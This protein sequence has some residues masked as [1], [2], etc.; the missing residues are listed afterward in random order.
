MILRKLIATI[1]IIS[2]WVSYGQQPKNIEQATLVTR[3]T[4]MQVVESFHGKT[5]I[6]EQPKSGD[7]N[8][9]T[10]DAN[11]VVPG[12]GFPKGQDP[13]LFRQKNYK[14]MRITSPPSLTFEAGSDL[15]S[16]TDPTGAVGPNHYVTAK[17]FSFTI[18]DK[19][20]NVL[21]PQTS[22]TNIFPNE[23]LG[24]PIVLYDYFADRFVITQF[25]K[26]P[27]SFLIAVSQ[28]NDPVNDGWY[29]YRFETGSFPDYPKFSVWSDG[30]YVTSNKSQNSQQTSEVVF[31]I[32]RE[33][34]LAGIPS[35]QMIGFPLPGA[36][37]GG[38]YS[39]AGFNVIGGSP[40]P[41]G[42]AKIVYFQDDA[43][44]DVSEDAIKL[45]TINVDW[46]NP[47][48]STIEEAE[49]FTTGN[50]QIT[51]FDSSFDGSSFSNLPQP[52]ENSQ[53]IDV[54]QGVVMFA[55]NYRRFCDYNS[56]LLNF[57]VD[58]DDREN[59][60]NIAAIRWYE[61]RQN[62]DDQSWEV[63]QEGTY[64]SPEGKSAWCAS[65]AMDIYGNIGMAYTTIGTI[66]NGATENSFPSI[67]Y[68]GRM[69]GD[70]LGIM[71]FSEQT[72]IAGTDIQRNGGERYGDYA[73]MTVDPIDDQTFW[74]IAEYF[75]NT[76]DNARNIVG[77]FSL[78]E[79]VIVDV[80]I[81]KIQKPQ[82]LT[83]TGN[84]VISIDI[85]NYGTSTLTEIPVQYSINNGEP[86][87]E[88][89]SGSI[90]P[91]AS[92]S[93]SFSTTADLSMDASYTIEART[94]LISDAIA[95][96]NCSNT[97]LENIFSNDV[98]V[99]DLVEPV[100][101]SA[102]KQI[103]TITITIQNLGISPQSNIPVYYI[104][105]QGQ[106]VN[107]TFTGTIDPG[108]TA[109]YTFM[110]TQDFFELGLYTLEVGTGLETDQNKN[111]D[112]I[113]RVILN[114]ICSPTSNCSLTKDGLTSFSLANITN[115]DITCNNGY[116]NFSDLI[117]NLDRSVGIYQLTVRAGFAFEDFERMTLWIDLDNNNNFESS[118]IFIDQAVLN[119]KDKD[120][121]FYISLPE[122]IA[123][124]IHKMRVKAGDINNNQNG[125]PFNESCGSIDF[126]TVHDYTLFIE[127]NN[128]ENEDIQ[129]I[130]RPN[131]LFTITM[132]DNSAPD[133]LRI[134]ILDIH[135]RVIVSN[136]VNKD[137][138]GRFIFDNL[139]MSYA[140]SGLYFVQLGGKKHGSSTKFIVP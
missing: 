93:Y 88:I 84:E 128:M 70:P 12:K 106:I 118:E 13:L 18:F 4:S 74:H 62:G 124:G 116:E 51:P 33:K 85:K 140:S 86:I 108:Q 120:L 11:R 38:F 8:P 29:T 79:P 78:A 105:N 130:S 111:N 91:G 48:Q 109:E 65:M 68:T 20:G 2:A 60:D 134:Y 28:G 117:I 137:T 94:E 39:P 10:K 23:S 98:R 69:D 99:L 7:I 112:I 56:V 35:A 26:T 55:T 89:Y 83:L 135:G 53:E 73:H 107:E 22:L 129:V 63:F 34:V 67:R 32:E 133:R 96:N 3:A 9:K 21:Q 126:G 121:D 113:T 100:S 66:E 95:K 132:T 30:Y 80:G 136:M 122:D 138:N 114:R 44:Q 42:N 125:D 104:L 127:D 119:E 90:A 16:P 6:K 57:S 19:N 49:E 46:Q 31:V 101:E 115:T 76:D 87:S 27:N 102:L 40:P 43:W 58:I 47:S 64:S 61:L 81:T 25:S 14:N 71:T 36:R 45:W 59:S 54:L 103:Q 123:L 17:N 24:D 75:E 52:E 77:V 37:T 15:K 41:E 92:V 97:T 72:I 139:D 5:L 82:N 1:F 131:D 50:D 110:Q